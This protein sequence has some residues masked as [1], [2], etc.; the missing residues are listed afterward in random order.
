MKIGIVGYGHVGKAMKELFVNAV[1]YDDKLNIG[2]KE[3]I[4]GCDNTFVCVPTP[5]LPDG[6][7]DTSIVEEVIGWLACKL[8]VLRS[9]VKVGFTDAMMER[10]G[11]EIVFQPE[12]YG[13]TVAHPF[14]NLN[15]RQWLAF[16]GT[17]KGIDLAIEVYQTVCNSTVQ[18]YQADAKT[19]E[20][21]K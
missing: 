7:C 5:S 20:M 14:K 17:R 4:N 1:V 2:S 21:A 16:G 9:T 12:Y 8:I 6:N 13:E 19:V 18:I 11:K 10:Y 3:E 15:D